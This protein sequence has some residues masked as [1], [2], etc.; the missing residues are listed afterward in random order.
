MKKQLTE[1]QLARFVSRTKHSANLICKEIY[2]NDELSEASEKALEEVRM[3]QM[4]GMMINWRISNTLRNSS[5]VRWPSKF[6][7]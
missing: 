2:A 3:D 7:D 5:Y 6:L 4:V 1:R